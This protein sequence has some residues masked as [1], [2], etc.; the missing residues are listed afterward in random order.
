MRHLAGVLALCTLVACGP[1]I[2]IT[3]P[4]DPPIPA[5]AR[6]AWGRADGPSTPGERDPRAENPELRAFIERA[7]DQEL[8]AK[9][10][11]R[12]APESAQFLVHYHLGIRTVVDTVR[13]RSGECGATPCTPFVWGHWGRPEV[14]PGREVEYQDGSLMIDVMD[15]ASGRL[16]WRGLAEGDASPS[17]T[18]AERERR[19]TKGVARLLRDF[20]RG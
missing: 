11:V 8:R 18:S 6:Y 12:T 4:A 2:R 7:I 5:A 17:R 20:P 10:F 3:R 13:Q 9:G 1:S 15:R 19:V 16:A 14:A